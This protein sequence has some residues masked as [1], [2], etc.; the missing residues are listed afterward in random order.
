[1]KERDIEA[2][3]KQVISEWNFRSFTLANFKGRGELLLR[4]DAT[5]E[6]MS[7]IE[8]SLM[9]LGSLLTNRCAYFAVLSYFRFCFV[10]S[11]RIEG[12]KRELCRFP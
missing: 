2:K 5:S 4:G 6:I 3:L 8:D 7:Q 12:I 9:T 10:F 11:G 1:V